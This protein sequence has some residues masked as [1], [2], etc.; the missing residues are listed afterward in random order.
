[1]PITDRRPRGATS[2]GTA[3]RI[4]VGRLGHRQ[5]H[6]GLLRCRRPDA[7]LGACGRGQARN[8]RKWREEDES[9]ERRAAAKV[10]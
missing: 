4:P 3:E 10:T 7:A 5:V 2:Q 9:D 8:R 1:M 6:A